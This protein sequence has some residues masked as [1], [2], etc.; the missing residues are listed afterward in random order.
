MY[1][2]LR[3]A[4]STSSRAS[5]HLAYM[6]SLP[7]ST[8]SISCL[9]PSRVRA[10]EA[11]RQGP[12]LG[13]IPVLMPLHPSPNILLVFYHDS[14]NQLVAFSSINELDSTVST[15]LLSSLCTLYV[16]RRVCTIRLK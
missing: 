15:S 2:R 7:N 16:N 13:V 11:A 10:R 3:M 1:L 4:H 14:S 5:P 6:L 12:A 9:F 8:T